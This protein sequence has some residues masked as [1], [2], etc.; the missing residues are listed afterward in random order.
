MKTP[1][2]NCMERIIPSKDN[3]T[4]CHGHCEREAEY[5]ATIRVE[6][7]HQQ[8]Q[9]RESAAVR[10]VWDGKMKRVSKKRE[11]STR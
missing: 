9:E 3:P 4:T 7:E 2:H 11:K 5:L 10:R 1:C 6:R 8:R